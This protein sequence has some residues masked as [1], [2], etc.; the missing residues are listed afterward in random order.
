MKQKK[1]NREQ[2]L[3]NHEDTL[4]KLNLEA[5]PICGHC[6]KRSSC[7]GA[8]RDTE[9]GAKYPI[10]KDEKKIAN[11]KKLERTRAAIV[12]MFPDGNPFCGGCPYKHT[13]TH[14][15]ATLRDENIKKNN[16]NCKAARDNHANQLNPGSKANKAARD[17]RANQLNPNNSST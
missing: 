16:A 17:N 8:C 2:F 12:E 6:H 5:N 4:S 11:A 7:A 13:C 1:I 3:K 14:P 10:T 9:A 15:C